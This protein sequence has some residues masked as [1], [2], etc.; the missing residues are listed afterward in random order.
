MPKAKHI[1]ILAPVAL[2]FATGTM[3][4]GGGGSSEGPEEV[5]AAAL[6]TESLPPPKTE[7]EKRGEALAPKGASPLLQ[8]I[9]RLFPPPK[10]D[11]KVKGSAEAIE[12]GERACEGKTP[13]EV[14]EEYLPKSTF[15]S[16]QREQA[17]RIEEYEKNP[18]YNF[19]AGQIA[20]S[21][22]EKTLSHSPL[23]SYGFQGCVYSLSKGLKARLES[24]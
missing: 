16:F 4:C 22:Y 3:G 15:D 11:P 5:S 18:T 13:V 1:L 12:A 19:P 23:A 7:S 20:A 17:T 8:A 24:K 14:R 21:I 6:G 2:M 9:Y 10:P